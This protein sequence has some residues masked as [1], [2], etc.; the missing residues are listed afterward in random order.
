MPLPAVRRSLLATKN[1]T[2][3]LNT[4]TDDPDRHP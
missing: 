2:A 3:D 1:G 4:A